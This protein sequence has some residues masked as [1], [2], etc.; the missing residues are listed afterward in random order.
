MTEVVV[1]TD[2]GVTW[3][4]AEFLDPAERHAWRRWKFDWI[5]PAEPGP[6]TL[7]A[8]A[9]DADGRVQPDRHDPNYGSYVINHPLP[10]EVYVEDRYALGVCPSIPTRVLADEPCVQAESVRAQCGFPTF[11]PP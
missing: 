9:R 4:R 3:A 5:T 7:L 8:R 2:G 10:I 6:Y 11:P 1:S